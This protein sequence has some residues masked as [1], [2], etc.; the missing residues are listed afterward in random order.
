MAC[1]LTPCSCRG[2]SAEERGREE[3][4]LHSLRQPH[5]SQRLR[6][7]RWRWGRVE[8]RTGL[9]FLG[10]ASRVPTARRRLAKGYLF[11]VWKQVFFLLLSFSSPDFLSPYSLLANASFLLI[12]LLLPPPPPPSSLE[13]VSEWTL[14]V[15][16][17]KSESRQEGRGN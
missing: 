11:D 13:A 14:M 6:R 8:R 17:T 7:R 15:M 1:R 16:R 9:P 10:L 2:E 3:S 5:Q 4:A 12:L